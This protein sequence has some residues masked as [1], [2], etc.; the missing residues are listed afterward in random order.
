MESK[1]N[2]LQHVKKRHR[3]WFFIVRPIAYIIGWIYHFK[4]HVYK[5]KA[6]NPCLILSNHQA[7][8]DPIFLALCFNKPIY[9]VSSD[10]IFHKGF[11][12]KLLV[13]CFAPI[14]RK[15]G[16]LDIQFIMEMIRVKN[17]GG[18]IA[19]FLEGN[20]TWTNS[21]FY[22]P[23]SAVKL[24][25]KLNVDLVLF[26]LKG[27]FGVDP[28]FAKDIRKGKFSGQVR[29]HL[30]KEQINEMSEEELQEL[31]VQSLDIKD[32]I[33]GELFKSK[34]RAEYLERMMFVCPYC[35]QKYT[36]SSNK[37]LVK[38]SSCG[39]EIEY[40]ENLKLLY[41]K[42]NSVHEL[43]DYYRFQL[44]TVI[45]DEIK[46]NEIICSD[47]NIALYDQ[48]NGKRILI[49]K[50]HCKLND[51]LLSIDNISISVNDITA[52]SLIGGTMLVFN[53]KDKEY[54]IIG[55]DRFNGF[56]YILYFN[57]V[58]PSFKNR[59]D[60]YYGLNIFKH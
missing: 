36:L 20:R 37:E 2:N 28:R 12:S 18:N 35:H 21:Q 60:S 30:S 25:K 54:L 17:Q 49:S 16:D 48:T 58:V 47:D 42:D 4:A 44:D 5:L 23:N 11:I 24:V 53:T 52:A 38:C 46:E 27:G 8:L 1:K 43:I 55:G 22:I 59:V 26:N 33:N 15:K 6:N 31:I 32:G 7:A 19:I 40:T 34:R 29:Y 50:G 45:K 51:K 41:K 9:F 56:K 13:H 10:H 39:G 57:R 3:F 14:P